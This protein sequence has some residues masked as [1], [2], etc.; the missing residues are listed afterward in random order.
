MFL[1]ASCVWP[2]HFIAAIIN[3]YYHLIDG[4]NDQLNANMAAAGEDFYN[5]LHLQYSR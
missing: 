1:V 5:N 3:S 4:A 2:S